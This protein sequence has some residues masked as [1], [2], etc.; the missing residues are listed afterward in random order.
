MAVKLN[1]DVYRPLNGEP[2]KEEGKQKGDPKV[3]AIADKKFADEGT[4]QPPA[5][6]PKGRGHL[7]LSKR[8]NP[9][10]PQTSEPAPKP[11]V[12]PALLP[13]AQ[14]QP[15]RVPVGHDPHRKPK[16]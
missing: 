3:R 9:V 12:Q 5:H 6:V 14:Q 7:P 16:T 15:K 8:V 13:S 4:Y 2:A 1:A 11:S 10:V